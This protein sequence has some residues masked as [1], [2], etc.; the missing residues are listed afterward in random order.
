MIAAY[1]LRVRP[2]THV[3]FPISWDQ[4]DD[5]APGDFTLHT[6]LR[7]LGDADPLAP[8]LPSPIG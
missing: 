5:V 8:H 6:A 4:L 2:G 3:S 1:S 7:H